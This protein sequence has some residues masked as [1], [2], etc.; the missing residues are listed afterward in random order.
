MY[1]YR[2]ASSQDRR[3]RLLA[4]GVPLEDVSQRENADSGK[5][6]LSQVGGVT[7]SSAFSFTCGITGYILSI[8]LST[9]I[10]RGITICGWEL[11]SPI[12]TTL[13]NWLPDPR[14]STPPEREYR[15]PV[16]G[17][18]FDRDVVINHRKRLKPGQC[19]EGFLLGIASERIPAEF[20]HGMEIEATVSLMDQLNRRF[21]FAVSLWIN[22]SYEMRR[23]HSARKPRARLFDS[24]NIDTG[25]SEVVSPKI[26]T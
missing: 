8:A 12:L 5:V 13:L 16:S 3:N 21:S 19:L 26:N 6:H 11:R 20:K 25:L 2:F 1:R 22:R 7:E 23:Q 10:R 17:L 9:E 18:A 24:P 15:F 4:A 14:E